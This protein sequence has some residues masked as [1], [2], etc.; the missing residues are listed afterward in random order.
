MHFLRSVLT[1]AGKDLRSELRS[2]EA[3][4]ASMSFALVVLLLLSFAFDPNSE[5]VREFSGGLLWLV[6]SFAGTLILNRS[7]ARELGNDCLDALLASPL[8][9]PALFMRR[10]TELMTEATK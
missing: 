8:P 7:F 4:N 6:F 2:K 9:S 3:I 10:M 1:I 5:Q